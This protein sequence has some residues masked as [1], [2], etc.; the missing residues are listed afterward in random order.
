MKY[1]LIIALA[2]FSMFACRPESPAVAEAG[3]SETIAPTE[4]TASAEPL[5]NPPPES[6]TSA[7]TTTEASPEAAAPGPPPAPIG[8]PVRTIPAPRPRV[9]IPDTAVREPRSETTPANQPVPAGESTRPDMPVAS[10]PA[11]TSPPGNA[12]AGAAV[13]SANK[14]TACHGETGGGDTAVAKNMGIPPLGSSEVA[15]AERHAARGDHRQRQESEIRFCT[16]EQ[17]SLGRTDP[18]C[19]RLDSDTPEVR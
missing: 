10:Q 8:S 18:R 7:V 14:C 16:Q 17:E 5:I 9:P 3:K 13:F 6:T 2:A 4:T 19:H 11:S 12:Q 1:V 15:V